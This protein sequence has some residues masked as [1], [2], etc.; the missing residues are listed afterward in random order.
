MYRSKSYTKRRGRRNFSSG[1]GGD[2]GA[3]GSHGS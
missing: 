2:R 3:G 1:G